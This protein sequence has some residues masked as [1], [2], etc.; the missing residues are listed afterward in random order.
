M[1]GEDRAPRAG[2]E[3]YLDASP[4]HGGFAEH[5]GLP[6][7]R[8]SKVDDPIGLC[9]RPIGEHVAFAVL[10]LDEP[11]HAVGKVVIDIHDPE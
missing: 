4:I 7:G 1:E 11:Q 10:R 8:P 5:V 2:I 9:G 6:V 3:E